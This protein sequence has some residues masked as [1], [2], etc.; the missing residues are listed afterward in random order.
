MVC[1]DWRVERVVRADDDG[2]RERRRRGRA[3][4]GQRERP[5]GLVW[6]VSVVVCGCSVTDA[7]SLAP[8]GSVTVRRSSSD[9]GYSWSGA[10][11]DPPA[12]PSKLC[13]LWTWQSD[14]QW[15]MIDLPLQ[16]RG[17][18]CPPA[19]R[20]R[21]AR[22]ENAIG[23]PTF[24]CS[25]A[26]GVSMTAVGRVPLTRI[27]VAAT[28]DWPPVSVT[29]TPGGDRRR[30]AGVGPLRRSARSRRR[31]RRRRRGPTHR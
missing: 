4:D 14:G 5:A 29:S 25:D 22:P 20:D 15:W 9:D 8:V 11:N 17:G 21:V 23:S 2:A 1:G 30:R 26:V 16:R 13:M 10:A 12:T 27:A 19:R 3:V 28:A 24:H 6:N 18:S 7:T 31:R